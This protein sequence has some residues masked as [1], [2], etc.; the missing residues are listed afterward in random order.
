MARK[1]KR[2]G[3]GQGSIFKRG[4][5][6]W[7]MLREGGQRKYAR[8]TDEDTAREVL[9]KATLDV[10]R[11]LGGLPQAQKDA[12]PLAELATDWLERRKKTHR[13]H[14]D[15][16]GRWN[17]H[18]CPAL[19]KLR[20]DQ[21][22]SRMVR[23]LVEAKL[24]AGLAAATCMRIV[25]C[26][27]TFYTD[28]VERGLARAN[29]AKNLPRATRRLIR[30]THDPKTVPF[31]EKLE[32]IQRI[33]RRLPEAVGLAFAIGSMAGLRT[34]EIL[35]LR[36]ASVDLERRRIVVSEQVQDGQVVKPKDLDSR[37]VPILES[38]QPVLK[39]WKLRTGGQGLVVTPMRS[40]GERL[41]QHTLRKRLHKAVEEINKQGTAL[42]RMTWYQA[43]RHTFASQWVLAGG[44]IEKL[45]EVMGH[46]S[47]VVTERYAHL[48]GDVF[49]A[50]DLGRVA[51]DF[52][53]PTGKILP[54]TRP[55]PGAVVDALSTLPL[56]QNAAQ[57]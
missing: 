47:V 19:G 21:A 8:F 24:A 12:A 48:R 20:P 31:L 39:A 15:D 23:D 43:T 44:S 37:T 49:S 54:M 18:L 22:T 17:L 30:S 55:D 51:V 42:P 50:A 36:W 2:R 9:A 32:D 45:R 57:T 26:L 25:R 1:P 53:Q 5:S 56:E 11:G 13:S 10:A 41:D 16:R 33:Y 28:L 40:D 52:G 29:P 14:P 3:F 34:G 38:L 4:S 7:V 35:A 6:W 27:S 46:C